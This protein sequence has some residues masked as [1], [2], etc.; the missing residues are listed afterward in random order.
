[1]KDSDLVLRWTPAEQVPT[2]IIPRIDHHIEFAHSLIQ[3][4]QPKT[5]AVVMEDF[6]GW[7]ERFGIIPLAPIGSMERD[8]S[9]SAIV[10]DYRK[11]L[12]DIPDDLLKEAFER[13]I[14][15][16]RFRNLPLYAEVRQ[17]VDDELR[18]RKRRFDK[19]NS[20][21]FMLKYR[22]VVES[23]PIERKPPTQEEKEMVKRLAEQAR[24][25]LQ[26]IA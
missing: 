15:N 6:I 8:K 13:T 1:M 25:N 17:Y 12:H 7:I 4:A 21:K 24:A 20:A 19:L 22:P 3:P 18:D 10:A 2:E 9:L 16:H 11:A 5:W 26:K 23:Q 14:Q